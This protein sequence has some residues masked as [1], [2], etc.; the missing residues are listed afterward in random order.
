MSQWQQVG[1]TGVD[2]G[3]IVI[4][5]PCYAVRSD[6]TE[7]PFSSYDTLLTTLGAQDVRAGRDPNT[8]DVYQL[9]NQIGARIGVVIGGFGGDGVFPIYVERDEDGMVIGAMIRFDGEVN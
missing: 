8:G 4:T 5:D 9:T 7:G 6:S 1:A 2:A 3:I